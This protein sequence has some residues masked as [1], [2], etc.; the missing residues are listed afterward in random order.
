MSDSDET[1]Y[2]KQIQADR[3]LVYGLLDRAE[4]LY[5]EV[6]GAEPANVEAALGLARVALER[7]DE[8]L[9]YE[10]VQEAVR[11]GPRFDDAVRLQHR[12]REILET[13]QRGPARHATPPPVRPSEESAF[14]RNR[15]MADHQRIETERNKEK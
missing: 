5:A 12:L 8:Q 15:S 9:A 3:L 11:I 1:S 14:M 10:R 2:E 4:A 6:L 7:G 13:R